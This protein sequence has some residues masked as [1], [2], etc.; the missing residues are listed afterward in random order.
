MS[1]LAESGHRRTQ[2]KKQSHLGCWFN[3]VLSRILLLVSRKEG[4]KGLMGRCV[5]EEG[6]GKCDNRVSRGNYVA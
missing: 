4:G 1:S 3:G 5:G 6:R 2:G